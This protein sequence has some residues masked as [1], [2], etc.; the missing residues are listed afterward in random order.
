MR[1]TMGEEKTKKALE[2]ASPIVKQMMFKM[3][4]SA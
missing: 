2:D 3:P 1:Y 4:R